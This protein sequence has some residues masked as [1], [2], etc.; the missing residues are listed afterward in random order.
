MIVRGRPPR[1][2]IPHPESEAGEVK[3]GVR[4][5]TVVFAITVAAGVIIF[6]LAV[7]GKIHPSK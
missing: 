1:S 7:T 3:R 4:W 6:L 5:G 2:P